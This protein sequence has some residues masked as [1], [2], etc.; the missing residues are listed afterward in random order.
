[1]EEE[2]D[3]TSQRRSQPTTTAFAPLGAHVFFVFSLPPVPLAPP[4]VPLVFFLCFSPPRPAF[5]SGVCGIDHVL[6]W[7][8]MA[9]VPEV[10]EWRVVFEEAV[11]V[12]V[13]CDFVSLSLR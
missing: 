2:Q 6:V 5:S 13:D 7:D 1:M 11:G 3:L 9:S 12:G 8:W 10:V 4:L